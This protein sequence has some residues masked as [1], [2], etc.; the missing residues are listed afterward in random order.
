MVPRGLAYLIDI[1]IRSVAYT[2]L[3][4]AFALWL[5][6]A[7][8]GPTLLASFL[9]EWFYPVAFEVLRRGQTPGK[10]AVGVR[11][12]HRDGTPVRWP[13]SLIR[14]LLLAADFLPMAFGFG[15]A[16]V[17]ADRHARRLG[18]LAAGTLVVHRPAVPHAAPAADEVLPEPTAVHLRPEEQRAVIAFA[19]RAGTWSEERAEELAALAT[20]LASDRAG[21]ERIAADLTGRRGLDS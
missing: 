18:D 13:A 16:S 7:A 12:V 21:L 14:N 3:A 20:P 17:L 6:D 8:L 11:V 5:G 15:I 9:I 2:L 1:S 19:E 4:V 10:A